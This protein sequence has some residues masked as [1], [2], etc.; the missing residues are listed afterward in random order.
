MTEACHP[1]LSPL[2]PCSSLGAEPEAPLLAPYRLAPGQFPVAQ[3]GLAAAMAPPKRR[4]FLECEDLEAKRIEEEQVI[5]DYR[6][7]P[8]D[9]YPEIGEETQH[10]REAFMEEWRE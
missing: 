6:L 1:P 2:H 7:H 4:R 3:S 5:E 8:L 9:D 10:R